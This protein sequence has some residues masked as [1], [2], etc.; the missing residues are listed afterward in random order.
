MF[1]I[2]RLIGGKQRTPESG[3]AGEFWQD[4]TAGRG[5]PRP[6]NG[7]KRSGQSCGRRLPLLS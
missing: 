4:A 7:E 3:F 6:Y 5:K 2:L 1:D